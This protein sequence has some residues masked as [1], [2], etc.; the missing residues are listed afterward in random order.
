[1]TPTELDVAAMLHSTAVDPAI[2][3]GMTLGRLFAS[4]EESFK[5]G[6]AWR[7]EQIQKRKNP[8]CD[9]TCLNYCSHG[10]PQFERARL[11]AVVDAAKVASRNIP[12]NH[13]KPDYLADL[14]DAIQALDA[15]SGV[16]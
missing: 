13:F 16:G 4:R 6:A 8:G 12:Y 1:M 14:D 7:E 2:F 5:A 9:E 11:L 10:D 3:D 15:A